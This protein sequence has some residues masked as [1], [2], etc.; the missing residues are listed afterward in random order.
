[1]SEQDAGLRII[2]EDD[3]F[4]VYDEDGDSRCKPLPDRRD[5]EHVV[6]FIVQ[7]KKF[8]AHGIDYGKFT[9]TEM[10]L[11]DAYFER[12]WQEHKRIMDANQAQRDEA[13]QFIMPVWAEHRDW[14]LFEVLDH[15]RSIGVELPK[16]N[17][18][19]NESAL[20]KMLLP[21]DEPPED[22][23]FGEWENG[24]IADFVAAYRDRLPRK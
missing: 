3:G 16:D 20:S 23:G 22:G 4:V 7:K 21:T 11:Y 1:M 14:T 13:K 10:K 18:Y 9:I 19:L 12:R 8:A 5:A 24:V 15:L 2:H 6:Q 17:V